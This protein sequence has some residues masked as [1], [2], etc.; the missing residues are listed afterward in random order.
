[1]RRAAG[2][3]GFARFAADEMVAVG[4]DLD[5]VAIASSEESKA[6]RGLIA[7]WY[8]LNC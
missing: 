2:R 6:R 1:M 7:R 8:T 4:D 5:E 3:R